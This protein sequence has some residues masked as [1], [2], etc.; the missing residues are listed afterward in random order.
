MQKRNELILDGYRF[1]NLNELLKDEPGFLF[2]P[3]EIFVCE[4]VMMYYS[5]EAIRNHLEA[6]LR[7]EV[8]EFNMSLIPYEE[9][10]AIEEVLGSMLAANTAENPF[11]AALELFFPEEMHNDFFTKLEADEPDLISLRWEIFRAIDTDKFNTVIGLMESYLDKKDSPVKNVDPWSLYIQEDKEFDSIENDGVI[12]SLF[13]D[14][15]TI[16]TTPERKSTIV[17]LESSV[18][19]IYEFYTLDQ[20]L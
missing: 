11:R 1:L 2:R 7:R 3:G 4:G 6:H 17:Y 13:S 18:Q 20:R 10:M 12:D 15:V 16:M 14:G 19:R 5:D 9:K 8:A